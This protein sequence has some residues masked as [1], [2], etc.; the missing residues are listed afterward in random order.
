[1][2]SKLPIGNRKEEAVTN[3]DTVHQT[4]QGIF[5]GP[6]GSEKEKLNTLQYK[7]WSTHKQFSPDVLAV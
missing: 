7:N 4:E 3:V 2:S 5:A 1:M 6:S